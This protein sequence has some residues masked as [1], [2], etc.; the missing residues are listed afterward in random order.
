MKKVGIIGGAGFIGSYVTKQFLENGYRVKVSALDISNKGKYI[1]LSTLPHAGNLELAPL[2]VQNLD[3]LKAFAAG[4]DIL[5]HSGTPFQLEVEDLQRD[6]LD[7]TI[8]GTENF[9]RVVSETP[10]VK[11][12]VFVASVAAHNTDFPMPAPGFAPD[13]VFS[14][15]DK[16]YCSQESHPYCQAKYH[17]NQVVRKF[18]QENPAPGFDIVTV[19]PVGVMG[20]QLSSREDSTS[21]GIQFLFKNKL[22]PNPF[23]Q[24]FY[25]QDV[26]W[27]LV[28]VADVA[29][30]VYKAAT[31]PNLHGKH[32]LLTGE[33]WRVSDISLMLNGKAPVGQPKTVY[34]NALATRDLGVQFKSARVPLGNYATATEGVP[35]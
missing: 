4:C 22:A 19:S 31:L 1:H 29:E 16:P 23:I 17:A 2:D 9:L 6:L 10:S 33:S 5:V 32:Y 13:H 21:M 34:S 18:T 24:M 3:Q 15:K 7:P 30:S 27:A 35:A 12:V 28:D 14:E 8:K 11:K 26:Y 25:D 20:N